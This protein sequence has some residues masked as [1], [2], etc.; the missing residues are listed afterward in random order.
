MPAKRKRTQFANSPLKHNLPLTASKVGLVLEIKA[1]P[2]SSQ[3]ESSPAAHLPVEGIVL[4]KEAST[5]LDVPWP[6][7]QN[8]A[9]CHDDVGK[10]YPLEDACEAEVGQVHADGHPAGPAAVETS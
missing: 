3:P 8:L 7:H 5:P 4:V 10:G 9:H 1:A 6:R 2:S